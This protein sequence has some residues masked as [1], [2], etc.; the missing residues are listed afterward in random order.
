MKPSKHF[1][2]PVLLEQLAL[3]EAKKI[4][5]QDAADAMGISLSAFNARLARTGLNKRLR[6]VR[7]YE[8]SGLYQRAPEL[9][10]DFEAAFT[11]ARRLGSVKRAC[12]KY[13]SVSYQYLCRM[14]RK[15][16]E[17]SQSA[18]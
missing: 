15:D 17:K 5:R 13:P 14:V 7:N 2:D 3:L 12:D 4:G 6:D 11:E 18:E 16:R 8:N 9:Q 10:G 1:S